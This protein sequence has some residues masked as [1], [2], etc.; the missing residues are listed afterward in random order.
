MDNNLYSKIYFITLCNF[1]HRNKTWKEIQH[2]QNLDTEELEILS[3]DRFKYFTILFFILKLSRIRPCENN[4]SC[5]MNPAKL[6]WHFSEF[7][8]IF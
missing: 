2:I 1:W 4:N 7:S 5:G 3:Y 6:V 8:T